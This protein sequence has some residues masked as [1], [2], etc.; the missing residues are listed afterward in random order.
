MINLK[1]DEEKNENK[2]QTYGIIT[3]KDKIHNSKE[4]FMYL[5]SLYN[6]AKSYNTVTYDFSNCKYMSF[7]CLVIFKMCVDRLELQDHKK[8]FIILGDDKNKVGIKEIEN[9]S[10]ENKDDFL[11][12]SNYSDK[13][14]DMPLDDLERYEKV[15]NNSFLYTGLEQI[16]G[17]L[18]GNVITHSNDGIDYGQYKMY[19]GIRVTSKLIQIIVSNNGKS[20]SEVIFNSEKSKQNEYDV[21]YKDSR[22]INTALQPKFTTRPN[23]VGGLGLS[24]MDN[25]V[26]DYFGKIEII[27]GK[28]YFCKEY[29]DE[30]IKIIDDLLYPIPCTVVFIEIEKENINDKELQS[31]VDLTMLNSMLI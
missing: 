17:E 11:F 5:I 13:Q 23:N 3:I 30:Y 22:F 9:L 28:A 10:K 4:G 31:L 18:V 1:K 27:S 6:Q 12:L 25:L 26:S 20:F 29:K 19:F 8:I 2:N 21:S 14:R 16:V 7:I 24:V 15:I